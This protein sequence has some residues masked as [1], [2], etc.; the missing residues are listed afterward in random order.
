[1]FPT[2]RYVCISVSLLSKLTPNTVATNCAIV[3]ATRFK[4]TFIHEYL[5][6]KDMELRMLVDEKMVPA[7]K[8]TLQYGTSE[9]QRRGLH[10]QHGFF[11]GRWM[12]MTWKFVIIRM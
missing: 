12:C 8:E 1:M 2:N 5:H 6:R 11:Y 10:H 9:N 7:R 4:V 3:K